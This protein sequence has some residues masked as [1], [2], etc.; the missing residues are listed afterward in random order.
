MNNIIWY[1]VATSIQCVSLSLV[2][3][4]MLDIKLS[5]NKK[6][7]F[8]L[9]L[10][11][12]IFSFIGLSFPVMEMSLSIILL[13]VSYRF[14]FKK[15]YKQCYIAHLLS[16]DILSSFQLIFL[17]FS[18]LVLGGHADAYHG[19]LI[20]Y[21]VVFLSFSIY[22]YYRGGLLKKV[23]G[24]LM[25]KNKAIQ[26]AFLALNVIILLVLL[27]YRHGTI[28]WEY[29][30]SLL[31]AILIAVVIILIATNSQLKLEAS[32]DRV[33]QQKKIN[34]EIQA[35]M[36]EI[37][38]QQHE[39]KN[40]LNTILTTVDAVDDISVLR[41]TL[42]EYY[43]DLLKK[44]QFGGQDIFKRLGRTTV[45]SLI[46]SK[47]F[48]A[49]SLKINF[50]HYIDSV[51]IDSGIENFVI[52]EIL[53]CLLDNAFESGSDS[54]ILHIHPMNAGELTVIA[55]KNKHEALS[56]DLIK[57]M[58]KKG[59]ST[60]IKNKDHIRGYGLYNLSKILE[61]YKIMLDVYNEQLEDGNYVVFSLVFHS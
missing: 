16:F 34:D 19:L 50:T 52:C 42:S 40:H 24:L 22:L 5:Q 59:F 3:L 46:V 53:G 25:D 45:E 58:F 10:I 38:R 61:A 21:D 8:I 7:I 47:A 17:Y 29:V 32:E 55:V 56:N 48:K 28:F 44:K 20:I 13:P 31:E 1:F 57:E 33:A 23:Y 11:W 27:F 36:A 54:V 18:S 2:C 14:L 60:K 35:L 9:L 4:A 41:N 15:G 43:S 51:T 37:V 26:G 6:S 39:N 12:N 30:F 49:S